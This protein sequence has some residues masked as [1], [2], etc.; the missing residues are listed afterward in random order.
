MLDYPFIINGKSGKIRTGKLM[1]LKEAVCHQEFR[2]YQERIAGQ[3]RNTGVRRMACSG[4]HRPQGQNLPKALPCTLQKVHETIGGRSQIP[5]AARSG[6]GKNR[7][8]YSA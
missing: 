7:Q 6:Q 5:D 1:R 3:G 4:A 2:A 8:E